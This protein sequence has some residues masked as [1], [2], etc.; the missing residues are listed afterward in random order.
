MIVSAK[1]V[2]Q[3]AKKNSCAVV[4]PDFL[5]LDSCRSFC[6]VADALK[7][8]IL[9]S[10][11]Q[12]HSHVLPLEEAALIGKYF[13]EKA[14]APIILHL[15]HGVDIDFLSRAIKLG[16]NSIMIDASMESFEENIRITRDVVAMA[17][18]HSR[19]ISVEAEIGHVGG[20]TEGGPVTDTVYTTVEEARKF[21]DA[22]GVDSLAVSVGTSH[23]AYKSDAPP[24][25]QFERLAE[26][27][28]AIPCPLVLHGGSGTGDDNLRK[29]SRAGISKLNLFTEIFVSAH[30]EAM[31]TPTDG[32][33]EM[34]DA[35][36]KGMKETLAHYIGVV[37]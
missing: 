9:L 4:A 32:Y 10:Y 6:Q 25:L 19:D 37:S 11:A 2:L 21:Y 26:L 16:F 24:V 33:V 7:K 12:A 3:D 17:H 34:M 5:D 15:D 28:T 31:K 36:K 30:R 14:S 35:A 27:K 22:T 18:A 23:G 29:A 8:P 20:S 13:A 1:K